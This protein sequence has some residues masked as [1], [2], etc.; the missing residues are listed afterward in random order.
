MTWHS[1]PTTS[2]RSAAWLQAGRSRACRLT[3]RL[4]QSCLLRRASQMLSLPAAALPLPDGPSVSCMLVSVIVA[5][6]TTSVPKALHFEG[7][8]PSFGTC[9]N[10]CIKLRLCEHYALSFCSSMG[11]LD[12]GSTRCLAPCPSLMMFHLKCARPVHVARAKNA[13]SHCCCNACS[14][15]LLKSSFML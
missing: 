10:T 4:R 14:K 7:M 12:D 15:S 9:G 2:G 6:C 3:I 11:P 5:C 1:T 13:L 8:P